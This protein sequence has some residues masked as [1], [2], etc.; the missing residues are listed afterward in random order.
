MLY[1]SISQDLTQLKNAAINMIK[2]NMDIKLDIHTKDEI[3]E[4]LHAFDTMRHELRETLAFLDNYKLAIDESTIVSKT[5]KK[6]IITY[7][8]KKFCELSG[9]T[10][11]E[12]LGKPHNIVRHPDNSKEIFKEMWATIKQKKIWKGVVKNR[13]KEGHDYI[14]DA[15]L[16]PLLDKEEEII[17]YIGIRHDITELE[18]SKEEIQKQKIDLLTKLPNR[19]KLQEDLIAMKSPVLLYFNIDNFADLNDFYGTSTGDNVL[20]FVASLFQ[21]LFAKHNLLP[22]K[23]QGDEFAI[24]LDRTVHADPNYVNLCKEV[25]N[26]LETNTVDC[27]NNKC[28]SVAISGGIALYEA[29]DNPLNLLTYATLARKTAKQENKKFLVYNRDMRNEQNYKNNITWIQKI[30]KALEEERIVTFFQPIISNRTGEIEKYES[31][32]RMIDEDGKVISPFFFLEISKKAKLYDK[33]TKIVID[34]TFAAFENTDYDFSLNLTIEDL[35]ND[36]M[37]EYIYEKLKGAKHAKQAVFEIT[38]SE[39]IHDYKMINCFVKKIKQYGAKIAIDDFGSGYA[40]FEHILEIDADFIKVDGSLI[41]NIHQDEKTRI[42]TEAIIS[43]SQKI[44]KKTIVEYVHNQEVL[45]IVQMLGADYS[46]GFHLGEPS[47]HIRTK[48]ALLLDATQ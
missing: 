46:Q 45:D 15:T 39:E 40:N 7:V 43:F 32:V 17:G 12:L 30:K 47:P 29:N 20:M 3:G 18:R 41:K 42:I 1:R 23:L 8:N 34:R 5:D 13:T 6:G 38:E 28:V 19:N 10:E 35:A 37:V 9:Y 11:K 36:E 31:L 14:V 44:G 24:L 48:K 26:Y 16:I 4:A 33:I 22:Y 25:I 21:K 27:D 2:G